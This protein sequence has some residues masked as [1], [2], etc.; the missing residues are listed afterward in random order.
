MSSPVSQDV[1]L[2]L[3]LATVLVLHP[4]GALAVALGVAIPATIAW[5]VLTLHLPSRV[6][7]DAEGISFS[8]YGRVHR[9]AWRA[10]ER[11]HVR[12][13]VVRDRVLVRIA[14]SPPFRGRYWLIDSIA[15]YAALV[16]VLEERANAKRR[17]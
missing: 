11:I 7:V 8:A 17:G 1:W 6:D 2:V 3:A 5:N 14:P 15:G 4:Q 13:F 16:Q 10:V 9:F 12:R